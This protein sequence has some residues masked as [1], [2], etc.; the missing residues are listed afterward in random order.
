L[1]DLEI[2][3]STIDA[4][5]GDGALQ[6]VRSLTLYNVTV[7]RFATVAELPSL[8]QLTISAGTLTA[9][10]LDALAGAGSL[11]RVRLGRWVRIEGAL[12][13]LLEQ[14]CEIHR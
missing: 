2:R 8:E 12:P 7:K 14:I 1:T 4:L 5:P 9:S 6:H 11:Q 13:P 3:D 10:D